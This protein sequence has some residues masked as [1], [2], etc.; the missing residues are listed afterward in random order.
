MFAWAYTLTDGAFAQGEGF[1]KTAKEAG[2][3][4]TADIKKHFPKEPKARLQ[5]AQKAP[6]QVLLNIL[7]GKKGA[8]AGMATVSKLDLQDYMHMGHTTSPIA[9]AN[10]GGF[11]W[12]EPPFSPRHYAVITVTKEGR[13]PGM[14]YFADPNVALRALSTWL[15]L[16]VKPP[17]KLTL[18]NNKPFTAEVTDEAGYHYQGFVRDIKTGHIDLYS[19][20]A[21]LDKVERTTWND[22]VSTF[23]AR[24]NGRGATPPVAHYMQHGAEQE[25]NLARGARQHDRAQMDRLRKELFEALNKFRVPE[26]AKLKK[27]PQG[28]SFD[29]AWDEATRRGMLMV[30]AHGMLA[31][32]VRLDPEETRAIAEPKTG[33]LLSYAEEGWSVSN[34]PGP[35]RGYSRR[36]SN[37]K[38]SR[39]NPSDQQNFQRV[40][41][42]AMRKKKLMAD[43]NGELYIPCQTDPEGEPALE[44]LRSGQYASFIY[45]GPWTVSHIDIPTT[46]KQLRSFGRR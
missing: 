26:S 11:Q 18:T 24:G 33:Q 15:S 30:S 14:L 5:L 2:E 36:A 31:V 22:W 34:T 45:A 4:I 12:V 21:P 35:R 27:N 7:G 38:L 43:E 6:D 8:Y 17:G 25:R 39:E 23:Q 41:A 20:D 10:P 13:I 16:T 44:D 32:P 42:V 29:I 37:K 1:A 3:A 19:P 28:S 9:E 46:R 40:W